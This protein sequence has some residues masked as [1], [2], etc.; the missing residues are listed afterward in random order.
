MFREFLK[1]NK[2]R[3]IGSM[4]KK[5]LSKYVLLLAFLLILPLSKAN[6]GG[7]F[8][9]GAD[10]DNPAFFGLYA[11]WDLRD[12]ESFFQV[13]NRGD[14][15]FIHIQVFNV[16]T[17]CEEIDFTDFY[18][19]NDTHVYDLRNLI[20][21]SEE[22]DFARPDLTDGYGFIVATPVNFDA[23]LIG[24]F[25]IIDNS[26]YE[27]R[28]NA[29]GLNFNSVI[30]GTTTF[31]FNFNDIDGTTFADVI[32]IPV[33]LD[34]FTLSVDPEATRDFAFLEVDPFLFNMKEKKH[35]ATTLYLPVHRAPL[36]LV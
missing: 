22:V 5:M 34:F 30:D 12:R 4:F 10:T 35:P 19:E 11:P 13:T 8:F 29:A 1:N 14:A 33:I 6:A 32:G 17:G 24:N 25:R 23:L 18:T 36:T 16:A 31:S 3:R 27:Y 26:G 28:A 15:D 7:F 2:K 20:P 9:S 21:N